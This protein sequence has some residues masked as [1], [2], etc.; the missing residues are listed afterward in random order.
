MDR[1][2]EPMKII[3]AM[4]KGLTCNTA[5]IQQVLKM[6]NICYIL[7]PIKIAFIPEL[8]GEKIL[9]LVSRSNLK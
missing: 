8:S 2:K 6:K 1:D 7:S 4:A 5:F 9:T 3:P